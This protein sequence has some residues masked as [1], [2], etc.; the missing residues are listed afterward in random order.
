MPRES[1]FR[2]TII[3]ILGIVIFLVALFEAFIHV[4]DVA[5][6]TSHAMGASRLWMIPAGVASAWGLMMLIPG[7][8]AYLGIIL[9]AWLE[10]PRFSVRQL[11]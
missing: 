11:A 4:A 8:A 9:W 5:T 6:G 10:R 1:E 2:K 3:V 7:M